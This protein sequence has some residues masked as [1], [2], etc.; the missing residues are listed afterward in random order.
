MHKISKSILYII[1]YAQAFISKH[2]KVLTS[3]LI[4]GF[5]LTLAAIELYPV[6]Q[7]MFFPRVESIGVIGSYTASI[8]PQSIQQKLSIGLTTL[9]S[10]GTALPAL[11]THW[12]ATDSGKRY[13]FYL[14]DDAYWHD[15]TKVKAE[16]IKEII[17]M[18]SNI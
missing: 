1:L 15:G 14:R 7:P 18:F 12:N 4:I 6:Y 8:L 10:D 9:N 16:D 11:A 2:F 13:I 17:N 3:G 5:I